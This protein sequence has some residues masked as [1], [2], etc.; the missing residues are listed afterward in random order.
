MVGKRLLWFSVLL[1]VMLVVQ[2]AAAQSP[3]APSGVCTPAVPEGWQQYRVRAGDTLAE[4]ARAAGATP[5]QIRNTNCITNRLRVGQIIVLP[6]SNTAPQGDQL[7]LQTQTRLQ[8][9]LVN[10]DPDQER[11][12]DRDRDRDCSN[13]CDQDQ[14][15]QQERDR[16][17]SKR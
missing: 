13:A 10:P 16:G 6:P 3:S 7:Q 2:V 17:S 15:R 1:A 4:L 9:Q 5:A 14:N 11:S 8:D 12:Q